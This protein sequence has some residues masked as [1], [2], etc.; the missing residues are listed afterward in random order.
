MWFSFYHK[1]QSFPVS[2]R[3]TQNASLICISF[4]F[5]RIKAVFFR[6]PLAST[7]CFLAFF[8]HTTLYLNLPISLPRSSVVLFFCRSLGRVA[9]ESPRQPSVYKSLLPCQQGQ[10]V[11]LSLSV[12]LS[13]SPVSQILK[14][15]HLSSDSCLRA[16][17]HLDNQCAFLYF[18]G[19]HVIRVN[20]YTRTR[21]RACVLTGGGD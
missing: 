4:F 12:S 15:R 16:Q 7:F 11:F 13:L 1:P 18:C 10:T 5:S 2:T 9:K 6:S 21:V 17:H 19:E 8:S 20:S 14:F 3:F